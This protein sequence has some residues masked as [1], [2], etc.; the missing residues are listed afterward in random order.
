MKY[1][2]LEAL[3]RANKLIVERRYMG[4]YTR[5][6][7]VFGADKPT[8]KETD[9]DYLEDPYFKPLAE[10]PQKYKRYF[11]GARSTDM[12]DHQ[13]Y[14]ITKKDYVAL[15]KAGAIEFLDF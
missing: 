8:K 2:E 14:K 15:L 5:F 10:I 13:F 4:T 3:A 9:E 7:T 11:Y 1:A 6:K 12:K